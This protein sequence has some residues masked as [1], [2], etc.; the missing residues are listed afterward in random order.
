MT[1]RD[2]VNTWKIRDSVGVGWERCSNQRGIYRD[3]GVDRGKEEMV[4]GH[5]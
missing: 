4:V 3:A 5:C 1:R 2:A